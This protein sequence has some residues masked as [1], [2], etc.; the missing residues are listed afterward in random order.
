MWARWTVP[1]LLGMRCGTEWPIAPSSS[2]SLPSLN[3]WGFWYLWSSSRISR[4]DISPLPAPPPFTKGCCNR[5]SAFGLFLGF[6]VR[7]ILTKEWKIGDHRSFSLRV[8]GLKP[9][10]DIRKSARMGCRSNIGG[11]SSASSKTQTTRTLIC[12]TLRNCWWLLTDGCYA[13]RPDVTQLVVSSLSLNG[14]HF[15]RHPVRRSYET[16]SFVYCG[17][18][19][20]RYSKVSKF[21]VSSLSQ[22]YVGP[23]DVSVHLPSSMEILESQQCFS[24]DI[25]D[26]LFSKRSSYLV[27]VL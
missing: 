25:S 21:D 9:L 13:C 27:N 1:I 15:W 19:L 3:W 14:G 4:T 16:L 23:L 7:E 12:L 22:Q 5:R 17:G 8:G 20:S 11:W 6:F 18:D 24:T 26:L 2:I 10:F